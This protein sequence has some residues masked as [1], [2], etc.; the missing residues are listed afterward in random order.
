M[1]HTLVPFRRSQPAR[2]G[3]YDELDRV[4][5]A[6]WQGFGAPAATPA[7][8][9]PRMDVYETESEYRVDA[10]LPGLNEK[11][12]QVTLE[13]GVLAISGERKAESEKQDE[14]RGFSHR[15]CVRGSFHRALRLPEDADEKGVSA[16]YK[17]G[18]LSIV[19]PKLPKPQPE[20]RTIPIQ[21]S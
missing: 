16:S 7:V 1:L 13:D 10:E 15:E 19:V 9:T 20:V 14:K 21:A 3:L 8:Y 5:D 4:F 11:D 6:F 18:V 17:N 2:A 12:I